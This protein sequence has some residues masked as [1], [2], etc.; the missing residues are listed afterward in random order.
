MYLYYNSPDGGGQIA[1]RRR[2]GYDTIKNRDRKCEEKR[3]NN[4]NKCFAG[5]H[6][7]GPV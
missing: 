2:A 6:G 7:D 4:E 1:L 3:K 5:D